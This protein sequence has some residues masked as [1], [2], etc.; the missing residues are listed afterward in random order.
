[1][2]RIDRDYLSAFENP[3]LLDESTVRKKLREYV[4]EGLLCVRKEGRQLLYAKSFDGV[5]TV[6]HAML[7]FYSEVAPCGII[8]S[9]LLDKDENGE[10][11]F[12]FKHHYITQALD[13]DVLCELLLAIGQKCAIEIE[14]ISRKRETPN[15]VPVV[16]LQI[17]ISVQTADNI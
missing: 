5:D 7:D 11:L 3:M 14:T 10:D 12:A 2:T 1:M 16:P 8:G 15:K 9:Y 6:N 4:S 13:S 17:F